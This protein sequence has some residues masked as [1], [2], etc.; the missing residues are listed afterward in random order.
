MY[1]CSYLHT[2]I[3][4]TEVHIYLRVLFLWKLL[5]YYF[6]LQVM[7]IINII[8]VVHYHDYVYTYFNI[9]PELSTD[10]LNYADQRYNRVTRIDPDDPLTHWLRPSDPDNELDVTQFKIF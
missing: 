8:I 5:L 1:I 10:S 9:S 4:I 7:W 2:H 6:I 3:S